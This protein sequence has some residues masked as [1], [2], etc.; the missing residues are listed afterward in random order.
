MLNSS[1]ANLRCPYRSARSMTRPHLEAIAKRPYI[2]ENGCL[3]DFRPSL[4][5]AARTVERSCSPAARPAAPR[6]TNHRR[7]DARRRHRRRGGAPRRR[8]PHPRQRRLPRGLARGAARQPR[9]RRLRGGVRGLR[10]RRLCGIRRRVRQLARDRIDDG[11]R[12]AAGTEALQV[13]RHPGH[14]HHCGGRGP[15]HSHPAV[16]HPDHLLHHRG[17]E[18]GHDVRRRPDPR[19]DCGRPV[20]RH[21]P[22]LR[23][24][25]ARRPGR[26]ERFPDAASS[27][28]RRS[29]SRRWRWSSAS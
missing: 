3:L 5:S 11:A 8:D 4:A 18:R 20:H 22:R 16:G 7:R 14:R 25:C 29:A 1:N 26:T 27:S 2:E 15:G 10:H 17:G 19:A 23:H 28:R 9:A 6:R 12:R 21:H 24:D 13:L